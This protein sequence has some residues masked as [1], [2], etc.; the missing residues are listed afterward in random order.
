MAAFQPHAA[1]GGVYQ[2]HIDAHRVCSWPCDGRGHPL[3]FQL[4]VPGGIGF[5]AFTCGVM[6]QVVRVL[7]IQLS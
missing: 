5:G 4:A 6:L 7:R 2:V 1:I 3:F